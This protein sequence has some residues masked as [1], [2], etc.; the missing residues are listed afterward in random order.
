MAIS[1][2][3]NMPRMSES[4]LSIRVEL[5]SGN[6]H[7]FW[8]R[9]GRILL[10]SPR[11]TFAQLADTIDTAFGRW[12]RAHL[13]QFFLDDGHVIGF[14]DDEDDAPEDQLDGAQTML[15]RLKHGEPF[16][17]EFDFGDSWLHLCQ[18]EP[19][20]SDPEDI[21]GLIPVSPAPCWGW[22]EL[23]DQYGRR[24]SDDDGTGPQPDDPEGTDLPA[25][26][27]WQHHRS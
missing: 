22:G 5:V 11:H 27:P 21:F 25:I 13:H 23:P 10:A 24:W 14:P 6:G 17:Y 1:V 15:A 4:W 18:P 9:P 8:P 7:R 16:V 20:S 3:E 2:T 19:D 26:G 12:D